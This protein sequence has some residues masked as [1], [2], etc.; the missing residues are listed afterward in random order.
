MTAYHWAYD[1]VTCGLT[2]K[3]PGSA[4]NPVLICWLL[5][6]RMNC[7][8]SSQREKYLQLSADV[9]ATRRTL[10]IAFRSANVEGLLR[11]MRMTEP[12]RRRTV[13]FWPRSSFDWIFPFSWT[14]HTQTIYVALCP[15]NWKFVRD[16]NPLKRSGVRWLQFEVFSA[17]QV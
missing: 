16:V 11:I 12:S 10:W 2:A 3:K 5:A 8:M 7:I 6:L 14:T 1:Y 17:I 4:L 9:F 13:R 15:W